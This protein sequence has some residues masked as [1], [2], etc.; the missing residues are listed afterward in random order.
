MYRLLT[1]LV[2]SAAALAQTAGT[3]LAPSQATAPPAPQ[4]PTGSQ[5]TGNLNDSENGRQARALINQTIQA[6]GGQAYLTYQN[7]AEEGRWYTLHHGSRGGPGAQYRMFTRFPDADRLEI[8][9]RGNVFVPLPIF[10]SIDVIVVSREKKHTNDLVIIHNGDKGY[11]TTNKGTAAE[12]KDELAGYL[13][14]RRHSL[15]QVLRNWI[16]APGMQYFYEGVTIVDG[17]PADQVTVMNNKDDS[18]TLY[19]DQNSH[20]PIKTS[21]SW[22]D[23]TDR[24]KNVEQ[25]T[26]DNYRPEQGIMTPHS[27]SRSFNGEMTHERFI[28]SVRYNLPLPANTFEATVTYDPMAPPKKR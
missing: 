28:N 23:P 7:K 13:R 20:L 12:D 5:A 15:D 1:L 18:V 11:E 10:G 16:N 25:E 24:Q 22:R 2:L 8:I 19:L 26:Y 27:I 3:P 9:A 21:F 14:R 6:L 4:Q 17:K